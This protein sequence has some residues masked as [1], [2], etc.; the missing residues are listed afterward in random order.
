MHHHHGHQFDSSGIGAR[1]RV[2]H[3]QMIDGGGG[4]TIS[5]MNVLFQRV[6]EDKKTVSVTPL[7]Q[8]KEA[9]KDGKIS[10]KEQTTFDKTPVTKTIVKDEQ[11]RLTRAL[12]RAGATPSTPSSPMQPTEHTS[13]VIDLAQSKQQGRDLKALDTKI[14]HHSGT[15]AGL[16]VLKQERDARATSEQQ[17]ANV[18]EDRESL[19]GTLESEKADLKSSGSEDAAND[20]QSLRT[21]AKQWIDQFNA[22]DG[23]FYEGNDLFG[24]DWDSS[25]VDFD[26]LADRFHGD[27]SKLEQFANVQGAKDGD[28]IA[29]KSTDE[30]M[31]YLAD[32][33]PGDAEKIDAR[34]QA[35]QEL[36]KIF[37]R[38]NTA[39]DATDT[40][41]GRITQI[42]SQI[43]SLTELND[44]D[45][46]VLSDE[47]VAKLDAANQETVGILED[48][49]AKP[50]E[51]KPKTE[52]EPKTESKTKPDGADGTSQ[53][54][55]ATVDYRS[56]AGRKQVL[57]E[58]QKQNLLPADHTSFDADGQAV[59]TV[60]PG[61]SYWHIA[62]MS[63]GR[64]AN[65]LDL[66]HFQES[67]NSNSQRLGRDPQV[68]MLYIDDKIVIP[69]RSIDDLV[70]LLGLST[71][72][73]SPAASGPPPHPGVY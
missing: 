20:Y 19:I 6:T 1:T 60:Q 69:N 57:A 11:S 59:Y 52:P 3:K 65:D 31:S 43:T 7:D 5:S 41:G 63:D 54:T 53:T 45:R 32:R 24:D 62:D 40:S 30:Y 47:T 49:S 42:D 18:I 56:E 55:D 16:A 67:L 70:E 61:D 51:S 66:Q 44:R 21:D 14:A 37:E 72:E 46:S 50:K 12:E 15:D 58:A 29:D 25:Q 23:Q 71:V 73:E 9:V 36:T 8:V 10:A 39:R 13:R 64:A 33:S 22:N 28:S 68:G 2:L 26:R 4:G 35:A 17:V 38:Y 48:L 34:L 27:P